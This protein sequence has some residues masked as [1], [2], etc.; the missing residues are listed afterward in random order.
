MAHSL[1]AFAAVFFV[2]FSARA[3]SSRLLARHSESI[4]LAKNTRHVSL[5]EII[6]KLKDTREGKLLVYLL[7]VQ[8]A[9]QVSGPYFVPYWLGHLRFSYLEVMVLQATQIAAKLIAAPLFG[10][11]ARRTGTHR[12]LKLAGAAI[13]PIAGLYL[14]S[15][16]FWWIVCIQICSG[17]AWSAY[18]LAGLLILFDAIPQR[19]RTSLLTLH[20]LAN[21]C[22]T[23]IGSILGALIAA[24][25]DD[26]GHAYLALFAVSTAGRALAMALLRRIPEGG[27]SARVAPL[28]TH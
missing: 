10:E 26:I 9:V 14:F 2:A 7:A 19:D 11:L 17:V 21:A 22:S 12:L 5:G 18:E 27:R 15:Q 28:H 20:N 4:P 13:V 23:V 6:P 3:F 8:I 25:F 24:R 1:Y 16:S